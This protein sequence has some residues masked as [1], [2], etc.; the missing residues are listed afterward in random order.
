ME[1]LEAVP[2]QSGT[3][4]V[5]LAGQSTVF[6]PTTDIAISQEAKDLAANRYVLYNHGGYTVLHALL[7]AANASGTGFECYRG[8]FVLTMIP[9]QKVTERKPDGYAR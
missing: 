9:L 2:A 1:S 4:S 3:V 8:K 5:Q 7:D 6:C